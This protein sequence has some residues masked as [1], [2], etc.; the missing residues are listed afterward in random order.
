MKVPLVDVVAI[1]KAG[2]VS[3]DKAGLANKWR[4]LNLLLGTN[5]SLDRHTLQESLFLFW[6]RKNE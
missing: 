3:D 4:K 6:C 5:V 1:V 2:A